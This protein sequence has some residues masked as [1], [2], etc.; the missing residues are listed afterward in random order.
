MVILNDIDA[1][2]TL[3]DGVIWAS[4]INV[5]HFIGAIVTVTV[6][7]RSIIVMVHVLVV[8]IIICKPFSIILN[9]VKHHAISIILVKIYEVVVIPVAV[10]DYTVAIV[11]QA[12][13]EQKVHRVK[14]DGDILKD[15]YVCHADFLVASN[16][17]IIRYDDKI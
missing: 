9:V 17:G 4:I 16:L 6:S 7:V 12:S 15:V 5:T 10:N 2:E 1:F 8:R 11:E 13:T 14:L 3:D